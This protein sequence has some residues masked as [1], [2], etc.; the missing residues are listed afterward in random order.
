MSAIRVLHGS[1]DDGEL[2]ALVAVLQAARARPRRAPERS[3]WGDPAWRARE[4]RAAPG[5]WRMSG[6]PR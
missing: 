2:A 3:A 4:V 6:L 5:A 1:P